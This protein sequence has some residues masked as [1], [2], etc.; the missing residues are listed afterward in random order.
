[1][2]SPISIVNRLRAGSPAPGS[3]GSG[4]GGRPR[5]SL[6]RVF[7][8]GLAAALTVLA[9]A[10]IITPPTNQWAMTGSHVIFHVV[11]GGTLPLA[12][13]WRLYGTNLSNSGRVSGADT[14]TLS[15]TNVQIADAGPYTVLVSN[16]VGAATN[17]T[18]AFLSVLVLPFT[19]TNQDIGDAGI[20]GSASY[21][22]GVF[23]VRGSG[24]DIEG[25]ADARVLVRAARMRIYHR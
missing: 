1:M 10:Y 20:P 14:D 19:W 13:Q 16:D 21:T 6:A 17:L 18:P 3:H 25:T 5:R 12:Y 4:G 11:A 15:I 8:V 9:P 7:A 22:N 2:N 24:E 23:T